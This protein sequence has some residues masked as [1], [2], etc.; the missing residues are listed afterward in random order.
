M[1]A[2]RYSSIL[3]PFTPLFRYLDRYLVQTAN[4]GPY[5]S[6]AQKG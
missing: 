2:R 6:A 5:R 4:F 3:V 1:R